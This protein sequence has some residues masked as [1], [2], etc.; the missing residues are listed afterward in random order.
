M[1]EK[2]E[3]FEESKRFCWKG[4]ESLK[5]WRS[6]RETNNTQGKSKKKKKLYF[7]KQHLLY[8]QEEAFQFLHHLNK[9]QSE[10]ESISPSKKK[11][12]KKQ[13]CKEKKKKFKTLPWTLK[14]ALWSIQERKIKWPIIFTMILKHFAMIR[15]IHLC[16]SF[17]HNPK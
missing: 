13:K 8:V 6:W 7:Q 9:Q 12:K 1:K 10:E 16:H 14:L 5:T 11:S 2:I 4:L 3:A 15:V 17:D